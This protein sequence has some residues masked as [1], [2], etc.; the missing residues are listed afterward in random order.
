MVEGELGEDAEGVEEE[1][2]EEGAGSRRKYSLI[3]EALNEYV[4][5]KKSERHFLKQLEIKSDIGEMSCSDTA[6]DDHLAALS[7]GCLNRFV[8]R[9]TYRRVSVRSGRP[10]AVIKV[11]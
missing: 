1:E 10:G 11:S 4:K 3:F 7:E 8:S 5:E 6:T 2:G 9:T